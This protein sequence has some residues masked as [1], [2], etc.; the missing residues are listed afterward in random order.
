MVQHNFSRNV[1]DVIYNHKPISFRELK[2]IYEALATAWRQVKNMYGT[3]ESGE[4]G[5]ANVTYH[6]FLHIIT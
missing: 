3:D 1:G 4:R 5:A 2:H 6:C